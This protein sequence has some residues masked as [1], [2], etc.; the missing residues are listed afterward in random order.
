MW[1]YSPEA[2]YT[3]ITF[4]QNRAVPLPEWHVAEGHFD[5]H[6]TSLLCPYEPLQVSPEKELNMALY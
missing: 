2:P 5:S 3:F 6:L 1:Q 4:L